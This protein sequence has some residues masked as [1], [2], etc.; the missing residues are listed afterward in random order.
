MVTNLHYAHDF[1]LL[2]TSEAELQKLVD[3]LSESA[4]SSTSNNARHGSDERRRM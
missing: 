1:I 4:Y 3:C 2:A